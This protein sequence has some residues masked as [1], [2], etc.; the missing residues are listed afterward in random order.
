VTAC[1]ICRRAT[2]PERD[3]VRHENCARRLSADLRDIPGHYALMGAVLAPGTAGGRAHVSG[4]R[5]APLPVRLEPLSLR[6]RGGIVTTLALWET[7]IRAERGLSEGAGRSIS[8]RDLAAMVLF[9]RAQ[10]PWMTEQYTQVRKFGNDLRDIVHDCRAAA[11]ILPN[12]MRIGDCQNPLGDNEPCGT[13]LYADP[14]AEKIQCVWCKR[15]WFRPQWM[16]L[17]KKLRGIEDDEVTEVTEGAEA[18]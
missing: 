16:A 1:T 10:L 14:Y 7:H 5:T 4:T 15:A 12:M 11:G 3:P 9:L 8:A 17:G 18:A 13:A 2:D 6:A